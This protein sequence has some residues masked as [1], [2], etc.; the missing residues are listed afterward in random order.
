MQS[1]NVVGPYGVRNVYRITGPFKSYVKIKTERKFIQKDR[2]TITQSYFEIILPDNNYN[3]ENDQLYDSE[4]NKYYIIKGVK[5]YSSFF[6]KNQIRILAE[7][8]EKYGLQ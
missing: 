5:P 2:T 7:E 1:E 4:L 3:I 6:I 8:N